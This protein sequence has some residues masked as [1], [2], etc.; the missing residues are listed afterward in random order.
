MKWEYKIVTFAL[1]DLADVQE[2][3]NVFGKDGW[4]LATLSVGARWGQYG[5]RSDHLAILKRP[6]E[7]PN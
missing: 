6:L 3:L 5:E 2:T 4:E 7:N 1:I